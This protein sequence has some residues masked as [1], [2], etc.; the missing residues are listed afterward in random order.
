[1]HFASGFC[2]S[3]GTSLRGASWLACRSWAVSPFTL[4]LPEMLYSSHHLQQSGGT[5]FLHKKKKRSSMWSFIWN[6]QNLDSNDTQ[7]AQM[8][9]T[10]QLGLLETNLC[11]FHVK[12]PKELLLVLWRSLGAFPRLLSKI[13]T[14]Y[15]WHWSWVI[16]T[17]FS[18]P[19]DWETV[20]YKRISSARNSKTKPNKILTVIKAIGGFV[21]CAFSEL[22]CHHSTF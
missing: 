9:P 15:F 11:L 14:L 8:L 20:S 22:E 7:N 5:I 12:I 16:W 1:M 4:V 21:W 6:F 19:K 3:T 13:C 10:F 18:S 2:C 17:S